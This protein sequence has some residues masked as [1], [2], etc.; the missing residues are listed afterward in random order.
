M[1]DF[2]IPANDDATRSID[3]IIGLVC[4]SIQEGLAERGAE[5]EAAAVAKKEESKEKAPD[6]EK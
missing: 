4:D 5:K 3:K 6:K 2:P 1:V